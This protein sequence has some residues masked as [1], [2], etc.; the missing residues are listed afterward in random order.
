MSKFLTFEGL[1]H[2][3]TKCKTYFVAQEA[4]KSLSSN[5]YTD[6]EK[7]KLSGVATGANKY[8]LPAASST[9]LGGVKAG[10]NVTV[11]GD[12]TLSLNK[13]NV[14]A[15]LGFT[16]PTADNN[17]LFSLSKTGSTITLTG[18]DGSTSSVEDNDTTYGAATASTA[19]LMSAADKTKLT[20]IAASAQ[21]NV[22]EQ[23]KL[24]GSALAV[25][26]K[27]VNIDLS[28][29]AL[30]SDLSSVY[31]YKGTVATYSALP[32]NAAVGDVYNITA[33]DASHNINAGDNVAWS[34]TDWD[35]QS[36]IADLSGYAT[37]AELEAVSDSLDTI[38]NAEIDGIMAG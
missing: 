19:G 3:W 33:A 16:P 25:S 31:K 32:S 29:Y 30:K 15:A 13:A 17:T 4:G 2:F 37:K 5:D 6:A 18:S 26:G 9:A 23:V 11:A 20:G 14:T 35:N 36:G 34:G 12:G 8:T 1:S 7:T 28:S 24:N 22:L 27:A 21:V 38:T 10:S